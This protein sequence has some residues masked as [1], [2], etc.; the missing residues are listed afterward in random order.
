MART[1][2]IMFL[3]V[4]CL[5]KVNSLQSLEKEVVK[6]TINCH[7]SHYIVVTFTSV[8]SYGTL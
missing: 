5:C 8:L 3:L 7:N 4:S 6:V 2:N 1:S